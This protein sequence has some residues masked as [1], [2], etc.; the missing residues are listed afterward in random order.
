MSG[1]AAAGTTGFKPAGGMRTVLGAAGIPGGRLAERVGNSGGAA[2]GVLTASIVTF[3]AIAFGACL[4]ACAIATGFHAGAD[5]V[6]S[7]KG[8]GASICT[9]GGWRTA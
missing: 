7:G 5:S 1:A 8:L 4:G 3:G 2:A 6:G 9:F